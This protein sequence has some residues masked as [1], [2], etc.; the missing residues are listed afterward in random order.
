M[1]NESQQPQEHARDPGGAPFGICRRNSSPDSTEPDT[2]KTQTPRAL[3]QLLPSQELTAQRRW[4]PLH[5]SDT[6]PILRAGC[7]LVGP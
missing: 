6:N 4:S 2:D 1:E 7:F 3:S 5:T